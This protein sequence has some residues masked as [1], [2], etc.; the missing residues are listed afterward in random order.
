MSTQVVTIHAESPITEAAKLMLDHNISGL[1]VTDASGQVVGIV[2]EHDLLRRRTNGPGSRR[3]WLRLMIEKAKITNESARF[4]EAK[5]QEVMTRN[6][7]TVTED[8]P[9]E[10]ACR[11]V[12]QRAIKRLPV[13]RDGQLVGIVARADL[14][15]ALAIAVRRVADASER[16][17]HAEARMADLQRQS[18][19]HRA[20][21]RN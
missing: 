6:P 17:A 1:P 14:V 21:S 16:A 8:T 2:T 18:L 19:L 20:R 5:V 9:V 4:Q 7:L 12:E 15:R 10:E 11:L 3:H 13:V